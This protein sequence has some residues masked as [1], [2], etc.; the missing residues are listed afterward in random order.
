MKK[1]QDIEY[2]YEDDSLV[3]INKPSGLLSIPDRYNLLLPNLKDILDK[4]YGQIFTCHRLDKETTGVIVF[5]K[6]A[7]AHKHINEQFSS[8]Q[9]TKI[10][11]TVVSGTF[12]KDELL[13][14]IPLMVNP[15]RKGGMIPSARGKEA[16]T[17]VKVLQRFKK[18]TLLECELL[19]GRQHQIR[20]HLQAI[21]YP[22][23]VDSHYGEN[24]AFFLSSIKKKYNLPKGKEELAI[25]DRVTLHSQ[26]IELKHPV[27]QETIK[28][29]AKY[30]KDFEIML[31]QLKKFSAMPEFYALSSDFVPE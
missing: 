3:I 28:A 12:H 18:A 8:H 30:P 2:V 31:K 1:K 6:T 26:R 14:D 29:E 27:T 4:K 10:Y 24:E 16:Y 25:I 17:K 20:T 22:L 13:I 23:L 11:H 19:T 5:A 15:S 7:A 9:N 21:G